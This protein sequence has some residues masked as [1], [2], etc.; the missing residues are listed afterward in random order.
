MLR[1]IRVQNPQIQNAASLIGKE[2][3]TYGYLLALKGQQK[4]GLSTP[5][6]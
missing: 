4:P 3:G 1:I 5:V 2:D 6:K